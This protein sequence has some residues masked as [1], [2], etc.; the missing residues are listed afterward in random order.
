MR[1]PTK[2]PVNRALALARRHRRR[3][4]LLFKGALYC[5]QHEWTS[6]ANAN[7]HH[8]EI[9]DRLARKAYARAVRL[10]RAEAGG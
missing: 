2:N 5:E 3:A 7:K 1:Q 10:I 8:A 4:V 9:A 6:A